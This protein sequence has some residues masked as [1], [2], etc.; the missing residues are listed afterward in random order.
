MFNEKI[1]DYFEEPFS[2]NLFY[3][4]WKLRIIFDAEKI[5]GKLTV[6]TGNTILFDQNAE[7]GRNQK[8]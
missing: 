6:K 2:P 3:N 1:K 4:N 7:Q 5:K 8:Q